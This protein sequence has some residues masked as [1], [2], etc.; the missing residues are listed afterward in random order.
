MDE[1]KIA[2]VALVDLE[3]HEVT[4]NLPLPV[5]S[6]QSP[7]AYIARLLTTVKET[8][9]MEILPPRRMSTAKRRDIQRR[10]ANDPKVDRALRAKLAA[11]PQFRRK[12]SNGGDVQG[13]R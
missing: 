7:V 13:S 2:P 9:T 3:T 1:M 8:L 5:R 4:N 6:P 12:D 11:R 10:A